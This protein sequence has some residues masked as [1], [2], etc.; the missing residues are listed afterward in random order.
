LRTPLNGI[1]GYAQLLEAELASHP[2]HELREYPQAIRSAGLHL[3]EL[4]NEILDLARIE[5][6]HLGLAVED[7][8]LDEVVA[9]CLQLVAPQAHK[10]G[11]EIAAAIPPA[12]TLRADRRRLKQVVLN[13]LSNAVKYNREAGQ[14]NIVALAEPARWRIAVAD[15]GRG[16]RAEA[17]GQLFQPFS[18]LN[19]GQAGIEGTGI[20]LVL[21]KRLV[22]A[23][24]GEIGASSRPGEGSEFW[25]ALP[26]G[27]SA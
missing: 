24:G 16:I 13:L 17:M 25:F 11:I 4:I 26:A 15:T 27:A 20:G 22:E 3:L 14:V 1:L 12:C 19:A 8:A 7:V 10:R 21:A 2:Q 6:G 5:A 18:R 23:M 9:E